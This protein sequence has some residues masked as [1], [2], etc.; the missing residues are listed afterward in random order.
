MEKPS[1]YSWHN[2][3]TQFEAYLEH[4][5]L[6]DNTVTGYV[7][8]VR[9]FSLWLA[10][11]AGQ[12]VS[13]A[14]FSSGDVEAYKQYFRDILDRS[15]AGIN[16]RLQ[17][18]RKFSRFAVAAGIRDTNPTQEVQLLERPILSA[19][20]TLT[21]LE[22][23]RLVGA[24]EEGHSPTGPR[25][26]A[27]LRLLL[28]TGIRVSELV[29]LQLADVDLHEGSSSLTIRGQGKRLE[30][31]IPLDLATLH[32]LWAYLDQPRPMGVPQIFLN[33]SG[34]P[35]SI[36]TVQQ[37]VARIGKPAGLEISV[38]TLR[39]TYA[40]SLWQETKDVGLLTERMG[41]RRPEAAL[42]YMSIPVQTK[43]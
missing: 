16:R 33:R 17:S 35:L 15:P 19:P 20:R 7:R 9:S 42:K 23:G 22:V 21:E 4:T 1:E 31:R 41:H 27:I 24:A 30:R 10:E 32:S 8:D 36:R 25:D 40:R 39:D 34:N 11:H 26:Y 5:G 37:I 38:K 13:P 14:T 2:V 28:Q 29:H 18:L 43:S 6:A 3:L 12:G